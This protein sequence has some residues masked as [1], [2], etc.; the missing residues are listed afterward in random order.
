MKVI[1]DNDTCEVIIDDKLIDGF[2]GF[3]CDEKCKKCNNPLIYYEKYDAF[4]CA[5]CNEWVEEKCENPY[6]EY[7]KNRPDRP[8][9]I[10][11][12]RIF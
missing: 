11:H 12:I 2:K 9:Q 7:C 4:F 5:Y 6:C 1:E 10:R 3:I 8:L